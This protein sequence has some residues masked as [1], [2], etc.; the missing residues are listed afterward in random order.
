MIGCDLFASGQGKAFSAEV[1]GAAQSAPPSPLSSELVA[2]CVSQI[3]FTVTGLDVV[4]EQEVIIAL[5]W[6]MVLYAESVL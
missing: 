1:P 4:T 3:C 5:V 6:E 2:V